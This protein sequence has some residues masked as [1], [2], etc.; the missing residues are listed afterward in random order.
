LS[1]YEAPLGT[2]DYWGRRQDQRQWQGLW[3][4]TEQ[5]SYREKKS[6]RRDSESFEYMKEI[7][8]YSNLH[9]GRSVQRNKHPTQI[10]SLQL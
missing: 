3:P 10:P 2:A 7:L 8:T 4:D 6:K 1:R 9:S 5:T